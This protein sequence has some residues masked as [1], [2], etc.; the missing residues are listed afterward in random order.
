[1]S[2]W[3]TAC[4]C[5]RGAVLDKAGDLLPGQKA[6]GTFTVTTGSTARYTQ[7]Y[8]KRN[9]KVDRYDIEI[10]EHL[11]LPWSPSDIQA[12]F[13]FSSEGA[14]FGRQQAALQDV[15]RTVSRRVV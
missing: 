3:V 11:T 15:G 14:T 2:A 4:I 9:F 7:P 6:Q 1:M 8:W 5:N 12:Q 10:P 13:R